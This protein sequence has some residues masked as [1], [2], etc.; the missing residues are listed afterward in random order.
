VE[1][2]R[3]ISTNLMC[4]FLL[5][6]LLGNSIISSTAENSIIITK[7]SQNEFVTLSIN[8]EQELDLLHGEVLFYITAQRDL[9]SSFN[10]TWSIPPNYADQAPIIID[11]RDDTTSKILC[12]RIYNDTN[13]PNKI[14]IFNIAPIEKDETVSV[15]FDYV[16]LV[17]NNKYLN[18]PGY[19][20]IPS[21]NEL[22]ED[23]KLWLAST[24]AIQSDNLIIKLKARQIRGFTKN[25]IRLSR[26]I[27]RYTALHR[28]SLIHTIANLL[29]FR[30]FHDEGFAKFSDA[31]S[32]LFLGGS[33][34]GKANL[35]TAL[36]RANN[37]P[38]KNLIVTPMAGESRWYDTHYISEYY[39]PDYGWIYAETSMF[40]TPFEPKNNIILRLNYPEDENIAGSGHD[41][42]GGCE[43]WYWLDNTDIL[44]W[45]NCDEASGTQGWIEK[46]VITNEYLA[47]LSFNYT[48]DV[49]ELHTRYFGMNLSGEQMI[50][51][52]N[53]V[54]A[55]HNAIDCLHQSNVDGYLENITIAY[56]EYNQI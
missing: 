34:T 51:Y 46:E 23:T 24:R 42:Y 16:T 47:D 52:N 18:L 2:M 48:R 27:V 17:K 9:D 39:C 37:V 45:W 25:L 36:F 21:E 5:I 10:V 19:V 13:P 12:Y 1:K 43:P 35:G 49:Y 4:F 33:C 29:Y 53:A 54:C 56:D 38:A 28:G 14:L 41:Y 8:N 11:I 55:Q 32:A 6:L 30:I 3:F 50:H 20:K 40:K 44:V 22:P 31:V 26:K 7:S 15:H